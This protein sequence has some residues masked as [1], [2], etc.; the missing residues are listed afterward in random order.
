[1]LAVPLQWRS[2][3]RSCCHWH[4]PALASAS[5]P[6][7]PG[8]SWRCPCCCLCRASACP[9]PQWG[10]EHSSYVILPTVSS[11]SHRLDVPVCLPAALVRL[12]Q[13]LLHLLQ[14]VDRHLLHL[15]VPA[16]A[17]EKG[18]HTISCCDL[19]SM[20]LLI[21]V[22]TAEI[23]IIIFCFSELPT[24]TCSLAFASWQV[25]KLRN[26]TWTAFDGGQVAY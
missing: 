23:C 26:G 24:V 13:L 2:L 7:T 6:L 12:A 1:M 8:A 17:S 22:W 19:S 9:A 25:I 11:V 5:P 14:L 3:S 15:G 18:L 20:F 16:I 21:S 4:P 10:T